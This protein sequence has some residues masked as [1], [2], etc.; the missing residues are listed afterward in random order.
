MQRVAELVEQ[1]LGVVEGEQRRLAGGRLVEV[2][3]VD[4]QRPDVA[5]ELLLVADRRHPGAAVL[6]GAREIIA[7]EQPHVAA[8]L[9]A[10]LPDPHVVV[11]DRNAGERREGQAEQ[12]V[13]GVEGGLDD[14]VELQV[15]L[16]R[17]LVDV[18]ARLAQ[19]LRVGA[20]VPGREREVLAFLLHQLLHGVAVGERAPARR[21]PDPVEQAAH[22][23]RRLRHRVVEPVLREGLVAQQPRAL[24]AQR[25]HL[26]DDRLV[27]GFAAAVA[28]RDPGAERL[29]AQVAARGKLQERLDARP[30]ERDQMLAGKPALLGVGAQRRAHEVGQARE[31]VLAL[32]HELPALLVG[33]HVLAERRAE[34]REAFADLGEPRFCRGVERRA[35]ALERHMVAIEHALLFGGEAKLAATAMQRVDPLEQR[36]VQVDR[37]PVLGALRRDRKLDLLDRVAGVGAGEHVKDAVDPGQRLA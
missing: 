37:V 29:L 23:L 21:G 9:A 8:V 17:G 12:P 2:H 27:V 6:G 11:P 3:H 24:G 26:G 20:P 4:D 15:G 28:A 5:L 34:R 36:A 32:Q 30:P 25:H 7:E 31:V 14:A 18:V 33:E 35:G 16:D 19:L 22:G 13:R 10:H 1:R